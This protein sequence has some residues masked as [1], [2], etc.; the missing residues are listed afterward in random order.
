MPYSKPVVFIYSTSVPINP[1]VMLNSEL[2]RKLAFLFSRCC[3]SSCWAV[4]HAER[5]VAVGGWAEQLCSALLPGAWKRSSCTSPTPSWHRQLGVWQQIVAGVDKTGWG[6]QRLLHHPGS[7]ALG[8]SKC[9]QP[10]LSFFGLSCSQMFGFAGIPSSCCIPP[11]N[12]A[13][14]HASPHNVL[15]QQDINSLSARKEEMFQIPPFLRTV[16]IHTCTTWVH[17]NSIG[18][19]LN[20]GGWELTHDIGWSH[21]AVR[22]MFLSTH[23]LAK[24]LG[25]NYQKKKT[26]KNPTAECP[27]RELASYVTNKAINRK[28]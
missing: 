24:P 20:L 7:S 22:N 5:A 23:L 12:A 26:P 21:L 25:K 17:S 3:Q 16:V 9:S 15:F 4:L 27:G 1:C 2:R 28:K 18:Y 13:E 11:L 19:C 14:Q 10:W 6:W 8:I